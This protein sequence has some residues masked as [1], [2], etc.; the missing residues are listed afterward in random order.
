[1]K[2]TDGSPDPANL[3]QP[4]FFRG[5]TDELF[6]ILSR[7]QGAANGIGVVLMTARGTYH[8]NRLSVRAARRLAAHGFHVIRF[9]FQGIGESTGSS[10][11]EPDSPLVDNVAGAIGVLKEQSIERLVLVGS[12]FGASSALAAT[13][14]IQRLDG[15]VLAVMPF[16]DER[17]LPDPRRKHRLRRAVGLIGCAV[18]DPK[19]R[20]VLAHVLHADLRRRW[21]RL[22]DR[23]TPPQSRI[24]PQTRRVVGWLDRLVD[25]RVPML[26]LFG[27]EDAAYRGFQRALSGWP[28]SLKREIDRLLKVRVAAHQNIHGHANVAAQDW[29]LDVVEEW[30]LASGSAVAVA[31]T[32]ESPDGIARSSK[33]GPQDPAS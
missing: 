17:S 1:M 19:S 9:D 7:P 27:A 18:V 20:K 10:T 6:G 11:F 8:R 22:H 25:R 28:R 33:Q 16:G 4:V 26:L 5:G 24:T 31:T 29:L 32:A 14:S 12:C 30:L 2:M 23:P 21:S 3:E 15:L 13:D